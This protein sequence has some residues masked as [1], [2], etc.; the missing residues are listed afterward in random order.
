MFG[1]TNKNLHLSITPIYLFLFILLTNE[2]LLIHSY[3]VI[4]NGQD[5]V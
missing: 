2:F 1:I 5:Q 3:V 4:N